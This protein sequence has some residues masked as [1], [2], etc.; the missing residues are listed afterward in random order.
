[1]NRLGQLTEL[2][3]SKGFALADAKARAL[4]ALSGQVDAQAATLAFSDIAWLLAAF[5]ALTIPFC[6]L[7][8][9][10]KRAANV[11]MH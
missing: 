6:F 11:E 1:M 9:S 4:A 10:G 7:L 3:H 5:T 2:F 8:T